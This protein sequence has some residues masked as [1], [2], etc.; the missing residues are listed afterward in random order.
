MTRVCMYVHIRRY[1]HTRIHT[2]IVYICTYV[3]VYVYTYNNEMPLAKDLRL[4]LSIAQKL[5]TKCVIRISL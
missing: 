3:Y 4:M 2:Y 5:S 1:I